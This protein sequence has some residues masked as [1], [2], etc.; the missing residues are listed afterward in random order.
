MSPAVLGAAACASVN[1]DAARNTALTAAIE[2]RTC[3]LDDHEKTDLAECASLEAPLDYDQETAGSVT[4]SLKR[5][6]SSREPD[7]VVWIVHGGPG[8]S[9]AADLKRLSFDI[10]AQRPNVAYYAVDHRGIG[11]SERLSCPEEERSESVRGE[12]IAADEWRHCAAWLKAAMP[13]R[14]EHFTTRN[15]ARDLGVAITKASPPNARKFVWGGSYGKYLIQRYLELYPTQADGVTLE[16]IAGDY[17]FTGYDKAM[18]DV[19]LAILDA[20]AHDV[21]CSARLNGDPILFARTVFSRIGAGHCSQ[22]GVDAARLRRFLGIFSFYAE[23]L[24]F[25]PATLFRVQR[26]NDD[27]V[28]FLKRLFAEAL[29]FARRRD[30]FSQVLGF[31]IGASELLDRAA[32]PALLARE[33]DRYFFSTG[34]EAS[35]AANRRDW[36]VYAPAPIPSVAYNKVSPVLMMQG[37]LDT[38]SPYV[39]AASLKDRFNGPRHYWVEFSQGAHGLTGNTPSR[40]GNDCAREIDLAF[41][42]QPSKRP[43][44]ECIGDI[45]PID[46]INPSVKASEILQTQD[47]W[48]APEE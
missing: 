36:P 3:F 45:R 39:K 1:D 24:N 37:L 7:T 11:G 4:L 21:V 42:D 26:C 10:P 18:N 27:D 6:V 41:L 47:L 28:A 5:T 22:A 9:A 15:A 13:A 30:G 31:H 29:S 38:P 20:C 25:I 17:P 48:G 44:T 35:L 12:T 43:S 23:S 34:L 8:A 46:W 14:L 16:A 32:D 33:L 40:S 2:W 19:G